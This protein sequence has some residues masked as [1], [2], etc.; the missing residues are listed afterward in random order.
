[1]KKIKFKYRG[2]QYEINANALTNKY[3][4]TGKEIIIRCVDVASIMKQFVKKK[5]PKIEVWASSDRYAGGSSVSV[6]IAMKSGEQVTESVYRE[7]AEFGDSMRSGTFDGMTDSFNYRNDKPTTD[8]STPVTFYTNYIFVD[9]RAMWNY[10][11]DET[12]RKFTK[13]N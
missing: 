13:T 9:N 4:G 11:Y 7:I 5:Y 12:K 2:E 6:N 8:N 3:D 1:M 10:K